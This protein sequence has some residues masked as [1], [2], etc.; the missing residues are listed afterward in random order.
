MGAGAK[1]VV[2]LGPRFGQ[3]LSAIWIRCAGAQ[4]N[5]NPISLLQEMPL[6]EIERRAGELVL[7]SRINYAYR[8]QQEYLQADRT[9]GATPC[10]GAAAASG[11]V[12]LG[13]IRPA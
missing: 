8:R 4:L 3:H 9:W 7:H 2:E 1:S 5:H 6:A 12:F 11:G 10:G 13:R